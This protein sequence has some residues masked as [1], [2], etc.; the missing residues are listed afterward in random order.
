MINSLANASNIYEVSLSYKKL[1]ETANLL[2]K[3]FSVASDMANKTIRNLGNNATDLDLSYKNAVQDNVNY[4]KQVTD[5]NQKN[6][7]TSEQIFFGREAIQQSTQV[8]GK[9]GSVQQW[10]FT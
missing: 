10:K 1:G 7:K 3:N 5:T 6:L 2:G 9:N 8:Y 4:T